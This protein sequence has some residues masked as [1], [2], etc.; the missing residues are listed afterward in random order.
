MTHSTPSDLLA[1]IDSFLMKTG[2]GSS[3]FGKAST[4]NSELVSRLRAGGRVWPDTEAAVR[5]FMADRI[6]AYMAA[7]PPTRAEQTSKDAA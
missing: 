7:N 6:R 2:M 4:G 1:E 5:K 3:Y